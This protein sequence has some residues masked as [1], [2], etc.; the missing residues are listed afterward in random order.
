RVK[1]LRDYRGHLFWDVAVYTVAGI[2][3][4]GTIFATD[5]YSISAIN[6]T[7]LIT[8]SIWTRSLANESIA[9]GA[10]GVLYGHNFSSQLYE[11]DLLNLTNTL[12][13]NTSG[14]ITGLATEVA[15]IPEPATML[16]FG[17]G[18]LGL[19]GARRK[20]KK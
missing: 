20:L 18:L 19:V 5:S 14:P 10:D 13:A 17:S 2:F 12:V 16:L 11:I 1:L 3:S 4:A 15:P 8:T 9:F 7:T 6:P